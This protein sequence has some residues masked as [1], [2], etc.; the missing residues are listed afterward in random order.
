MNPASELESPLP[1]CGN[2]GAVLQGDYCGECGQRAR[3]PIRALGKL[4]AEFLG[5]AVNFD[6]RVARTFG[7]LILK[8]GYL[9]NEYVGGKRMRYVPPVRLYIFTSLVFF[10]MLAFLADSET[11]TS[12][13]SSMEAI[14][15][16]LPAQEQAWSR[17]YREEME[18]WQRRFLVDM[19]VGRSPAPTGARSLTRSASVIDRPIAI[20]EE[21]N[22]EIHALTDSVESSFE[23][24]V[25][26]I[27]RDPN[28]LKQRL[29][30]LAPQMMFI[31]LP[32]FALI[33]KLTYRGSKRFYIEH[34]IFALHTHTFAFI[35]FLAIIGLDR[36]QRAASTAEWVM[37]GSVETALTVLSL[38]LF[39]WMPIY[40]YMAMHRVYAQSHVRTSLKFVFLGGIYSV[41]LTTG[42]IVTTVV[43][44]M[45]V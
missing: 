23:R 43:S 15:T 13:V 32:L 26:R 18:Q 1:R 34:L 19:S 5:E 12:T 33:L 3:T 9:T 38:A 35:A 17:E 31:L 39:L 20:T 21:A 30:S 36:A 27:S 24:Q 10:L 4:I 41:L 14:D 6:S 37:V 42:L 16:V 11:V 7:R 25:K 40:L 44:V 45:T 8:P 2:C 22:I 28:L 29:F